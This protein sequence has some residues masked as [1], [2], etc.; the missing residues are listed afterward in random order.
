MRTSS[1]SP[2]LRVENMVRVT[3]AGTGSLMATSG[4]LTVPS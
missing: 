1:A 4:Q 2:G 3:R